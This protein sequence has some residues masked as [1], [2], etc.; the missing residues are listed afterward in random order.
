MGVGF[1]RKCV[2][3]DLLLWVTAFEET[4]IGIGCSEL[5][6]DSEFMPSFDWEG[7]PLET[8]VCP[9][10]VQSGRLREKRG[11]AVMEQL[12]DERFQPEFPLQDPRRAKDDLPGRSGS[13]RSRR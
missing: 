5:G 8:V 2:S 3:E 12:L 7:S 4:C 13:A 6:R 10:H 11:G 9:F 1:R